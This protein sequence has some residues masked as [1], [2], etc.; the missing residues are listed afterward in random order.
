VT[1]AASVS[2]RTFYEQFE[3]KEQCFLAAF[4][5][6]VAHVRDSMTEAAR[7]VE[8][9]EEQVSAALSSML[10]FFAAEPDLARFCLIEPLRADPVVSD[11][12]RETVTEICEALRSTRPDTPRARRLPAS[13]E[14]TLVGGV[15][16]LIARHLNAG[17]TN[18]LVALHPQL[19]ELVLAPYVGVEEAGRFAGHAA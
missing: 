12:Y 3:S 1:R 5:M 4:D 2:R 15:I 19:L 18:R 11:H 13:T 17:E 7:A 8:G 16:S 10:Q 6:M 14:E 9:W